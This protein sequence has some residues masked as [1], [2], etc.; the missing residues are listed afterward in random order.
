MGNFEEEIA[1]WS[2]AGIDPVEWATES[3][4]LAV[5][6]G[7]RR[8]PRHIPPEAPVP[9]QSCT[10]DNDIVHRMLALHES[11]SN[12]YLSAAGPVIEEQ[13]TKAGTRL[14]LVLNDIWK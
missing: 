3:H 11:V 12:R 2:K 10:D 9:V 1:D 8:L 6:A 4:D 5:H 7:Y 14:A 13:L